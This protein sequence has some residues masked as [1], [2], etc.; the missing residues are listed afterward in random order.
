MKIDEIIFPHDAPDAFLRRCMLNDFGVYATDQAIVEECAAGASNVEEFIDAY[1]S[2]ESERGTQFWQELVK[3]ER[4]GLRW[5]AIRAD[6][7]DRCFKTFS[8]AGSV[9]VGDGRFFVLIPNGRGDGETRVAIFDDAEEFHSEDLMTYF[10]EISGGEFYIYGNDC[11]GPSVKR[12]FGKF[13][14]Y[15]YDGLVAFL[16]VNR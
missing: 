1:L 9:R 11:G 4:P 10:T 2:H 15:Y 13:E 16:Q 5:K 6:F 14:V 7:G 12:L 3:R 8:D